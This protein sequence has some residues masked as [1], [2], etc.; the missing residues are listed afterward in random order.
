MATLSI[1]FPKPPANEFMLSPGGELTHAWNQYFDKLAQA[2]DVIIPDAPPP[3]T[4]PTGIIDGS[5]APAGDI[6]EYLEAN[7]TSPFLL[8]T[9]VVDDLLTL[10]LSP[11][12]WDVA[13]WAAFT[14]GGGTTVNSISFGIDGIDVIH[15]SDTAFAMASWAGPQRHNITVTTT[16]T[17]RVTGDFFGGTIE[18]VGQLRARRM[19]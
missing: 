13:A 12:D 9:A 7:T 6:G 19:R 16:V 10:D 2:I 4:Y 5:D 15:F 8:T 3:G 11:G 14:V 18:A 17:L 1:K